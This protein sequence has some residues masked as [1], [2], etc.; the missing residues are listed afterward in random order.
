MFIAT[1][2]SNKH[3]ISFSQASPKNLKKKAKQ[4]FPLHKITYQA[5]KQSPA[6]TLLSLDVSL[7]LRTPGT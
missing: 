5:P 7:T 6:N 1:S 4:K 3:L 2:T